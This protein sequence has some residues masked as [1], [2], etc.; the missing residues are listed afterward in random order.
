MQRYCPQ[1]RQLGTMGVKL[2]DAAF[3]KQNLPL[4]AAD[5]ALRQK[6]IKNVHYGLD[7]VIPPNSGTFFGNFRADFLLHQAA[8]FFL[9][10]QGRSIFGVRI[11]GTEVAEADL[12]F[13]NHR[14]KVLNHELWRQG[15]SNSVDLLFENT[16]VDNSAGLHKF[17]DSKDQRTYIFSHCEPYFCHRWFPC[18]DQPS[19]RATLDL[20]VTVPGEDWLVVANGTHLSKQPVQA[21]DL[22]FDLGA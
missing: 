19:V 14:I 17:V 22:P 5:A 8:D 20:K 1:L 3:D 6:A 7:I 4:T 11:N 9:D 12:S 16:F 2:T 15:E 21:E 10:F 18:F 13:D